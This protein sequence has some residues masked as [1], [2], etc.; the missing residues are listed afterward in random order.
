MAKGF[1]L[2]PAGPSRFE[3]THPPCVAEREEDYAEA[4]EAWRAGEPEEA[5]EILR[6]ALEDCGDNLWIHA[7]LGRLALESGDL[8]LARGH[9]GYAVELVRGLVEPLAPGSLDPGRTGNRPF[10]DACDG[11]A[12]TLERAGQPNRAAEV[13]RLVERLTRAPA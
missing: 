8:P 5:R 6:F 1:G 2:K 4:M 13:R 9:F 11:L 7:A 12:A 3:L 10:L